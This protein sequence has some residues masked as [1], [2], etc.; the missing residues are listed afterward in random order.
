MLTE[1]FEHTCDLSLLPEKALISDLGCKDMMFT[2][3]FRDRGHIVDAVDIQLFEGDYDRLAIGGYNGTAYIQE[4]SDPQAFCVKSVPPGEEVVSCTLETFMKIKGVEIYDLLKMDVE[5]SELEIIRSLTKPPAKQ[6]SIEF[7]CHTGIY[8]TREVGEMVYKLCDLG[9]ACI[10]HEF[11][12]RHG[13]GNNAW[14]SL[15]LLEN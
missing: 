6:I 10:Q 3:Y 15:F 2:N 4:S 9:Y 11:S 13:A 14:D 5:G 12:E 7:H 8:T 1:V